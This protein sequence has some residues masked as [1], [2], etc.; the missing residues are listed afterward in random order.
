MKT[1]SRQSSSEFLVFQ[2]VTQIFLF[3]GLVGSQQKV[4]KILLRALPCL[5]IYL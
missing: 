2:S 3:L 5:T 4:P 1:Q